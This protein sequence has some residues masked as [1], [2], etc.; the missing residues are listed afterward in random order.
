MSDWLKQEVLDSLGFKKIGRG[1]KISRHTKIIGHENI[2]LG[3]N[4]R[5]DHGALI[6]A[7]SE[8]AY[9]RAGSHI[10]IA[11]YATLLCGGGIELG[12]FSTV[13][14][15]SQ[16]ISASDDFSGNYLIGPIYGDGF[17]NVKRVPIVVGHHAIITTDCTLLPGAH[18]E[19]GSVLGAKA[20]LK[21]VAGAGQ[22]WA[23]VPARPVSKR[24]TGF[25]EMGERWLEEWARSG[26]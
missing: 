15:Q 17:T 19:M 13:G 18:M 24:T 4:V 20:L 22:V 5:I 9:L 25:L 23:G 8:G 14:I 16:L 6:L 1:C 11:A 3:D 12:N 26:G 21:G 10:H 2:E 7:G